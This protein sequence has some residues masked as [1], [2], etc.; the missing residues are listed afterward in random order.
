MS[1]TIGR[2]NRAPEESGLDL[3]YDDLLWLRS[4]WLAAR[5]K[6]TAE[7]RIDYEQKTRYFA[8]W[9]RDYGPTVQWRLTKRH[10]VNFENY[11]CELKNKYNGRP[12]AWHTRHNSLRRISEMFKWAQEIKIVEGVDCVTWIPAASGEA[13]ERTAPTVDQLWRLMEVASVSMYPLRN[14][15]ILALFIGTGVR[16]GELTRLEAQ[17]IVLCADGSGTAVVTGKRTKANRSGVRTVAFDAFTGRY[18]I[19][20][21]DDMRITDG[22]LF[23]SDQGGKPISGDGIYKM[24]K[25]VIAQAGLGD[26]IQA[27]H[28]FRRAFSTILALHD[29]DDPI[30]AD[31]IRRQLGHKH[32]SQTAEYTKI[33][34]EHIRERIVSPLTLTPKSKYT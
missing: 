31:M 26:K 23:W 14:Q 32:Y 27:C 34:A 12:L 1:I 20:Y 25:K 28:D 16:L 15:T 21:L 11:L 9:W 22:P 6:I 4:A 24:V 10:M 33:N 2:I 29:T 8:T 18:L 30:F 7:T 13:P 17:H 5:V 3:A 19:A